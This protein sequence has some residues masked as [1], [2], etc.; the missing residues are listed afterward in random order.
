[1]KKISITCL[2]FLLLVPFAC[3]T[4]YKA[5]PLP[6]KAPSAYPN[7]QE[8]SGAVVA[9]KAYA[10]PA[11]AKEAFGFDVREAGMLPI[12]VVFDNKGHH[13]LEID[14][15]QTFLEDGE[16]DLWPVLEKNFAYERA[17]RYAQT[18]QI[19]KEG[20]YHGF[21][22]A[23]AGA[24]IGAAVGI[25]SGQ[26][27]GEAAGKGAA[28]GAAGGGILGGIKGAT[29]NEASRAVMEDFNNKSLQSKSIGPN[30]LTYGFIF[31]PGE[32]K[33]AKQLRLKI[34]E[35]DTGLSH[36]IFLNF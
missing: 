17:T 33:S 19:F 13:T 16:G 10:D 23:A 31:Y 26:N 6:F 5:K 18:K 1:M 12:S 2:V 3:S 36:V 22:G 34:V 15:S 11:E 20:A 14:A 8:I 35:K 30:S 24:L 32:A 9:A 4:G 21:I 25:V 28:V 7:A 29:S 27:V